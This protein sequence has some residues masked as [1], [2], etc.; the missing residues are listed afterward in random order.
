LTNGESQTKGGSPDISY[1]ASLPYNSSL[2]SMTK[3]SMF[4]SSRLR[5]ILGVFALALSPL[6]LGACDTV[7]NDS[8]QDPR[9]EAVNLNE[10][11]SG[12]F[13][14]RLAAVGDSIPD[15]GGFYFD[16]DGQPN[17]YL[18]DPSPDRAEEVKNALKEVLGDDILGRG[19]SPRREVA[20]PQIELREGTYR[21][22]DLIAWYDRIGRTFSIDEVV[23]VDLQERTNRLTVGVTTLEVSPDVE[24]I[25]EDSDIPREAVEIVEAEFPEVN[26]HGLN[27]DIDPTRG[28][29]Q[30][31]Y[32]T[33][34]TTVSMCSYGFTGRL[35]GNRGFITNSHCTAQRGSVTGRTFSNPA[36]GPQIGQETVDPSYST[37]GFFQNS[38]CRASDAAFIAFDSGVNGETSVARTQGWAGPNSGSGNRSINHGSPR[39]D[40]RDYDRYPANGEMVDKVG[41]TTGWTYGYVQRTCYNTRASNNGSRVRVN[42]N[43]VRMTCQYSA[44]YNSSGGDSGSP[45][46]HWHGNEVT[47]MGVHWGSGGIFSPLGGI[48]TD[49]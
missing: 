32:R 29:I 28:G 25:L 43:L 24:G 10:E 22:E 1:K 48:Q 11:P 31:G 16:E 46:F 30:I 12:N 23:F 20:N 39:M 26:G 17:V 33:S 5:R 45:V 34:S 2:I 6:L 35:N 36:T 14:D 42:G 27:S 40:V 18:L 21:M 37:C 41:R 49:F 19:D 9:G 7:E 8:E 15:F 38:S 13:N 4:L 47:I 44:S 3:K